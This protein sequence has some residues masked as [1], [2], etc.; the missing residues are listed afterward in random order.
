MN[1][2]L[3]DTIRIDSDGQV[4]GW[5]FTSSDGKVKSKSKHRWLSSMV[6][7]KCKDDDGKICATLYDGEWK[8]INRIGDFHIP[9]CTKVILSLSNLLSTHSWLEHHFVK[10]N[11]I[12]PPKTTLY[13]LCHSHVTG[14]CKTQ[15]VMAD[16][17]GN[18]S[19]P[20]NKILNLNKSISETVRLQTTE[21]IRILERQSNNKINKLS[22]VYIADNCHNNDMI[23]IYLHH[24]N[25][26]EY[27]PV[28]KPL[29]ISQRGMGIGVGGG[30]SETMSVASTEITGSTSTT[31]NK[32][33]RC[34]GDF[35][36]YTSMP[37]TAMSNEDD[38][39]F[40]IAQESKKALLRH[41]RH[42][43]K[44]HK[45]KTLPTSHEV[46]HEEEDF[47]ENDGDSNNMKKVL[48]GNEHV[49]D[50]YTTER[51]DDNNDTFET[52]S[53]DI[54][55][56]V[57]KHKTPS[58]GCRV[59][60][61]SIMLARDDMRRM[62]L[63]HESGLSQY[64]SSSVWPE[65]IQNWFHRYGRS[66]IQMKHASIP[67]SSAHVINQK[68]IQN[69]T[70]HGNSN[71]NKY[72][73][74]DNLP[75]VSKVSTRDLVL[76]AENLASIALNTSS[77]PD[78]PS[79]GNMSSVGDHSIPYNRT[80]NTASDE[81][82]KKHIS[83]FYSST[84][85]C[86]TCY[87]IYR[88]LDRARINASKKKLS[89][90]KEMLHDNKD[91]VQ[92]NRL[93]KIENMIKYK[94]QQSHNE[95]LA[96]AKE[97]ED[98]QNAAKE[99]I[100]KQNAVYA[101]ACGQTIAQAPKG[102]LPPVPWKL[103]D[104]GNRGDYEN[105]GSRF[106][107]NIGQKAQKMVQLAESEKEKLKYGGLMEDNSYLES[108]YDWRKNV[109]GLASTGYDQSTLK[110]N[111]AGNSSKSRKT[112]KS[113]P[114]VTHNDTDRLLHPWQRDLASMRR[115]A[116]QSGK[117]GNFAIQSY[118]STSLISEV[119]NVPPSLQS[120]TSLP[121]LNSTGVRQITSP[122]SSPMKQTKL[123][124]SNVHTPS[125]A[126]GLQAQDYASESSKLPPLHHHNKTTTKSKTSHVNHNLLNFAENMID[127]S[128]TK[129]I[130]STAG[131]GGVS[132]AKAKAVQN[133]DGDDDGEDDED[134]DAI[135]WSPF[136]VA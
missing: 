79:N 101:P 105:Q 136:M 45:K 40:D 104:E 4:Y 43:H 42:H 5:L 37:F 39:V 55:D 122:I 97:I 127:R 67:K 87:S 99:E 26:L 123:H 3:L 51:D 70:L 103:M 63:E 16:D 35:C 116:N 41:K 84:M 46:E 131:P 81:N 9:P 129:S 90:T 24:V 117:P 109:M 56:D 102:M 14:T 7:E 49:S 110:S 19:L 6:C 133:G 64:E 73:L 121:Q 25:E 85:V 126:A 31:G 74:I 11:G 18:I 33:F 29:G 58:R 94:H 53:N 134:D 21:L 82:N 36:S 107:K 80:E 86:E 2:N 57:T 83:H 96:I 114:V 68:I 48:T 17:N 71:S 38:E 27:E 60:M 20:S 52:D 8:I 23:K 28:K 128:S 62:L 118:S 69:F 89:A 72:T 95:R 125:A 1:F 44:K 132:G 13:T 112:G 119:K 30:M 93:H 76:T 32:I 65:N 88:E 78:G 47:G 77:L 59:N 10:Q 34:G 108:D 111:S 61:K 22:C 50:R 91:V 100:R 54:E 135:G 75:S 92:S 66:S 113:K 106:I 130:K 15:Q 98:N 124:K 115:V 120:S 12:L